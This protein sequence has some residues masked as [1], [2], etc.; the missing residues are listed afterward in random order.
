MKST[1]SYLQKKQLIWPAKQQAGAINQPHTPTGFA[2]LDQALAG[3]WP[4]TGVIA[5]QYIPGIGECRLLMPA[6]R[7]LS[8]PDNR[9]LVFIAP[10]W[11]LNAEMLCEQ[12][13]DLTNVLMLA[14][15]DKHAGLWSAEQ[16]LKSGCC[17]AVLLWSDN[18]QLHQVKRLQM[19]AQQGGALQI[20]LT[21][22]A[23]LQGLPLSLALGLTPVS[24]GLEVRINKR[25]GGWPTEAFTVDFTH[26]WA[27]L[28]MRKKINNLRN[29]TQQEASL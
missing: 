20:L 7:Q 16:C 13:L 18:L 14:P 3:G 10:P 1:I 12:A 8:Q 21:Q 23:N 25:R 26:K 6:L 27:K 28:T 9:L 15:P 5:L 22:S 11:P 29:F 24:Q 4:Q 17:A 2:E 19:A